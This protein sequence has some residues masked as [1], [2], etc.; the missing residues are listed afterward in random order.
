MTNNY[1]VFN[2]GKRN[3]IKYRAYFIN[4]KTLMLTSERLT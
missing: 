4:F 3:D 2:I 1:Q